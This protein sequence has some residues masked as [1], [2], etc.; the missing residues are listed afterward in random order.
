MLIEILIKTVVEF[1]NFFNIYIKI[2][3]RD[4]FD[5]LVRLKNTENV[6]GCVK[7]VRTLMPCIRDMARSG[8]SA[9]NV[10]IVL[11]ACI[12]PAPAS[13]ATKLISDT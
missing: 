12:P 6:M 8:L 3:P 1:D 7:K 10:R 9:L 13:E 11:K 4:L 2:R 5:L